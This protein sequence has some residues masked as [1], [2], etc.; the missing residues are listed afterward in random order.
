MNTNQIK[1]LRDSYNS[2]ANRPDG[3]E[4]TLSEYMR[5]ITD[6]NL[7]FV[8]S[9]DLVVPDDANELLHCV[10][11]NNDPISQCTFPIKVISTPYEDIHSIEALFSQ[12]NFEKF[13]DSGFMKDISIDKKNFMIKWTRG[14]PMQATQPSKATPYYTQVPQVINMVNKALARHDDATISAPATLS[15][16]GQPVVDLTEGEEINSNVEDGVA[17][18]IDDDNTVSS[19]INDDDVL[20]VND[21]ENGVQAEVVDDVLKLTEF[22]KK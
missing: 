12:E 5:F 16:D 7:E 18:A 22:N 11:M 4:S 1:L 17:L 9:K 21:S 13:L 15:P 2:K 10:C 19:T 8:T 20:V 6:C 14:W 3:R